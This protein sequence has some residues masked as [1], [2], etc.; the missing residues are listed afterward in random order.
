MTD[1]PASRQTRG[2]GMAWLT[3]SSVARFLRSDEAILI[4]VRGEC[5]HCARLVAA[6]ED[7]LDRPGLQGVRVGT[8]VLDRP[9]ARRF[10]CDNPWRGGLD[11][12]PYVVRYR[13]GRRVS[14]ARGTGI[15]LLTTTAIARSAGHL[16]RQAA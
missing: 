12:F 1:Q 6:V 15:E 3:Q 4:L 9:A 13:R 2:T 7:Q 8:L 16:A 5:P 11:V 10:R 14:A